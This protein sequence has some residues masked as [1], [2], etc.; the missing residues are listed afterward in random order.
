GRLTCELPTRWTRDPSGLTATPNA[1]TLLLTMATTVSVAVS[2]TSITLFPPVAPDTYANG[3]ALARPVAIAAASTATAT[4]RP[5]ATVK[6]L[7]GHARAMDLPSG[8]TRFVSTPGVPPPVQL[9]L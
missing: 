8:A 3:V 4:T 6:R 5:V 7:S 9:H 2:I 1:P